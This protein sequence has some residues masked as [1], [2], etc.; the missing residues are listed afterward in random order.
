MV[1]IREAYNIWTYK[2]D[3]I[4]FCFLGPKLTRATAENLFRKILETYYPN[5][6]KYVDEFIALY[7]KN[8]TNW[9]TLLS[10]LSEFSADAFFN[11]PAVEL[12]GSAIGTVRNKPCN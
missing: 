7:L 6:Q 4:S 2:E 11:F 8:N 10:G 5:L 3:V 9:E 12:A 1:D